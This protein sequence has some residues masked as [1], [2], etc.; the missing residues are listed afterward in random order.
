MG[1]E[2][3]GMGREAWKAWER[4]AVQ[5]VACVLGKGSFAWTCATPDNTVFLGARCT[6][7]SGFMVE[8]QEL[9]AGADCAAHFFTAVA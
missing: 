6:G 2:Q 9:S 5:G 7:G 3:C 8:L 4:V 1:G